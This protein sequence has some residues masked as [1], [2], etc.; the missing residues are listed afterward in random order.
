MLKE[1]LY[2]LE[3][4]HFH[5]VYLKDWR[6]VAVRRAMR[7]RAFEVAGGSDNGKAMC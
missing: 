3:E 1:P 6:G 5:I 4:V 7:Q 2:L